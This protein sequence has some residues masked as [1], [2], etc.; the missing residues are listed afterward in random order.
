ME[1]IT[2]NW[3]VDLNY[4]E[5][6]PVMKTIP[7]FRNLFKEDKSKGKNS[8]SKL[9]WAIA[10]LIDPNEENP[11]RNVSLEDKK[12]LIAEDYLGDKKFKWDDEDIQ[13]LI[14]VYISKCLTLMEKELIRYEEKLQQRGDFIAKTDYSLDYYEENDKGKFVM[15][16][17]TA[18]QLD[19]MV[20]N[21]KK[22]FEQILEIKDLISQ[23][24]A[25]GKIKGGASESASEKG[26]L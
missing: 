24:N 25:E 19:R 21:S 11:W 26:L 18:D 3:N 17:G 6:H 20:L 9:L 15:K 12:V 14:N 23:Q 5:L 10:M 4:W 2:K 13:E 22:L 16:K 1:S 7:E 8:S